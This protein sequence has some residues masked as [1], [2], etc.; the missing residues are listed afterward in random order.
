MEIIAILTHLYHALAAAHAFEAGIVATNVWL[1]KATYTAIPAAD[2]PHRQVVRLTLRA[3]RA[4]MLRVRHQ[5]RL[6]MIPTCWVAFL[7]DREIATQV[8]ANHWTKFQ[9]G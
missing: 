9:Q 8:A 6:R 7:R 2:R 3:H 5:H 4:V 1:V